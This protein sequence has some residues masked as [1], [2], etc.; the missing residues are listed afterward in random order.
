MI[1]NIT[2]LTLLSAIDLGSALTP[3]APTRAQPAGGDRQYCSALIDKY[4]AYV[5]DPANGRNNRTNV[6]F[7]VAISKCR[8]GDTASGIPPLEKALR[9][10]RID[11]PP[12][13]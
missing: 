3:T 6:E 2:L 11:L 8:A 10:A 5:S 9:D 13:G 4:R 7:E 1:R 12:H